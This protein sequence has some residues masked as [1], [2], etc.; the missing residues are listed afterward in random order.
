MEIKIETTFLPLI[1]AY[2]DLPNGVKLIRISQIERRDLGYESIAVGILSFGSGVA[3]SIIAAWI[4]DKIKRVS[5]RSEFKLKIS[6]KE[7]IKMSAE[8]ITKIIETE[9]QIQQR[10]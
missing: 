7:V 5:D 3:A 8:E 1:L 9:I 6:G 2:D 10:D 4:Y